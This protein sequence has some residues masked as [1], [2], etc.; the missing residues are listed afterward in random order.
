MEFVATLKLALS[1]LSEILTG[2]KLLWGLY[3]QAKTEGWL[4][5][6]Q[7]IIKELKEATTDEQRKEIAR[8]LAGHRDIP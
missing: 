2:A 5:E 3:K 4:E 6:G 8:R 7:T 1:L